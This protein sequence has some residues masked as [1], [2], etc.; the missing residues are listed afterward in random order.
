M[1]EDQKL[2]S[3]VLGL[4]TASSSLAE[5]IRRTEKKLRD[6]EN[7]EQSPESRTFG[8]GPAES[9]PRLQDQPADSQRQDTPEPSGLQTT[10]QALASRNSA[11][12]FSRHKRLC[13]VC[14]HPDREAIEHDFLDWRSPID[15]AVDYEVDRT[16]VLRHARA[17]GL[18]QLRR[19]NIRAALER[20]IERAEDAAINGHSI[21]SA[22]RT[23]LRITDDGQLVEPPT[24]LHFSLARAEAFALAHRAS[25]SIGTRP[26][27][28]AHS[29]SPVPKHRDSAGTKRL[30][31][32]RPHKPRKRVRK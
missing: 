10:D 25:R 12:S 14:R 9:P 17:A 7:A 28:K 31:R 3:Q 32:R 23:Y 19:H 8:T 11:T 1:D 4:Q 29:R 21:V 16:S 6:R 22:V 30:T 13:Q 2:R 24:R 18:V 20:V 15:I 26:R 5:F 27:L